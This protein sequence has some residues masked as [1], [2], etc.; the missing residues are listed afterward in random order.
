MFKTKKQ[1]EVIMN[2]KEPEKDSGIDSVSLK[3]AYLKARTSFVEFRKIA[4]DEIWC[5]AAL[6]LMV[7]SYR[8]MDQI[9]LMLG[10]ISSVEKI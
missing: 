5:M 4:G 10:V 9:M 6:S 1:Q 8:F 2:T 3:D 7:R